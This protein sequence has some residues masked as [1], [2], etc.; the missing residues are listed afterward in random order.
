M[1]LEID[2]PDQVG[3][4]IAGELAAKRR[5][6]GFG[7]RVYRTWDPRA[8]ILRDLM[9]DLEASTGELKWCSMARQVADAVWEAKHLY[10]NV[11]FYSAPLYYTPG[12]PIELYT[13]VFAVSRVIGWAAHVLEQYANNRLIRP[14]AEYLGPQ[15]AEYVPVLRRGAAP[16]AE[17]SRS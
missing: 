2:T 4:C 6:P 11:D 8:A 12:I 13:P 16:A 7:H 1:L 3:P 14:R 9:C 10:P 17:S 15:K 5:I